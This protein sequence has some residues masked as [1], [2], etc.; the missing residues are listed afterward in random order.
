MEHE[1]VRPDC[2]ESGC[3]RHESELQTTLARVLHQPGVMPQPSQ[4]AS[5]RFAKTL[6]VIVRATA[7]SGI[8]IGVPGP[9]FLGHNV[10]QQDYGSDGLRHETREEPPFSFRQINDT[11]RGQRTTG[12]VRDH[13]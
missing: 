5:Y 6:C 8:A 7:F 12:P 10:M 2:P 13:S 9:L 1:G 4:F 11:N 3:L